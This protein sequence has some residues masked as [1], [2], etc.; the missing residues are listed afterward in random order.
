[1]N[2]LKKSKAQNKNDEAIK[3]EVV[4]Q[5]YVEEFALR[6]FDKADTEDRQANFNK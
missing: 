3:S 4:G 6:I 2:N 5:T 1:M